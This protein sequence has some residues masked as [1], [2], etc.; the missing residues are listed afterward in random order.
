[1]TKNKRAMGCTRTK[2]GV[3]DV[4]CEYIVESFH[5]FGMVNNRY[6]VEKAHEIQCINCEGV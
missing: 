6:V 1:M 4:G 2:F 5:N 3:T